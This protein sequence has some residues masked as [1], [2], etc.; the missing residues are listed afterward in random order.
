MPFR[1]SVP[2]SPQH[3]ANAGRDDVTSLSARAPNATFTMKCRR[4]II[5]SQKKEECEKK[6]G[7]RNNIFM[8][9][10]HRAANF[11]TATVFHVNVYRVNIL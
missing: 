2:L 7:G 3:L 10:M 11:P 8:G 1:R 5:I 4:I 9:S 6:F